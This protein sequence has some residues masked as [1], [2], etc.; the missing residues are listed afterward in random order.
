MNPS[1]IRFTQFLKTLNYLC[2]KTIEKQIL[3]IYFCKWE[4][5]DLFFLLV[6]EWGKMFFVKLGFLVFIKES[7]NWKSIIFSPFLLLLC[8]FGQYIDY[9]WNS[10]ENDRF[11]TIS[12]T[13]YFLPLLLATVEKIWLLCY[14]FFSTTT[15]RLKWITVYFVWQ[16]LTVTVEVDQ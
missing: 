9:G 1:E 3:Y 6:Q 16:A 5:S 4:N 14:C 13:V 7:T 11:A 2:N 15:F 8:R 12:N 10:T